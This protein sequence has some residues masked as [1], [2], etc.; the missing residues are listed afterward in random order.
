MSL[1]PIK[2]TEKLRAT[3]VRYLKTIYPF[4]DSYLREEFWHRLAEEDRLVKGPLL[5][6]SPPFKTGLTIEEMVA[7]GILHRDFKKLCLSTANLDSPPLP[8]QRPLY[9]HQEKAISN[10]TRNR[11]NLVVATGTGSGKTETFL[12]PILNHLLTEQEAGTLERP[13]VRA[14]L[15]YPMNALANDQ[16]M[17]LRILLQNFPA[18]TFGR[19]TGETRE[20]KKDA[21]DAFLSLPNAGPLIKNE[22]LSREEMRQKPPHILL[23]NYAML[24]YLL[25]RPQ[26]TELFDGLTG[27]HWRF[28]IVDEAHVYDGANGIEVAMLLRRLKDRVVNSQKGKLTCIATSATIGKGKEDF[29]KVAQFAQDLF[30]EPFEVEDVFEAERKPLDRSENVWGQGKHE[31]YHELARLEDNLMSKT[32]ASIAEKYGLP[33][34]LAA[35]IR[36]GNDA[37]AALYELLVGDSRLQTLQRRLLQEPMMLEKAANSIFPELT[38]AEANEAI[39]ALV[40]LAVRARSTA[41]SLPLLPARYHVFAR[42]TEGAFGCLHTEAHHDGKPRIYLNRHEQCAEPDCQSQVFELATCANCGVTYIVGEKI[43][44]TPHSFIHPLKGDFATGQGGQRVYYIVAEVLPDINEDETTTEDEAVVDEWQLQTLCLHCGAVAEHNQLHCG[45]DG[46]TRTI[47]QA[48]FNGNDESKMYCPACS[49]RSRSTVYRMLTGKD[50]PVSVLA[51]NLYSDL[52][53]SKNL[54]LQ[55]IPGQGRKLLM[56]ADSRQ[57]AAFFAPYFESNYENILQRRLINMALQQ[58]E[59]ALSGELRLNSVAKRLLQEAERAGIFTRRQDYDE[60]MSQMK[61]WLIRE[62][63]SWGFRQSLERLGL[64]QFKLVSPESWRPAAPLMEKPWC[65][66]A[67]EVWHLLTVLLDSVRRQGAVTFPNGVDPREEFFAPLNRPYYISDRSLTDPKYRRAHAVLGWKP[68]SG[69]NSRLDFLEKLLARCSPVIPKV[70][71]RKLASEALAKLWE[72]ELFA[73]VSGWKEYFIAQGLGPAGTAYQLDFAFWEW[74]PT[75]ENTQVWRCSHCRNLAYQSLRG[76]CAT[77]GCSGT[78]EP[79]SYEQL[80]ETDNHYRHLYGHLQ[81]AAISVQEHTAQWRAGK[82][83]EIQDD[84]VKGYVNVL[85]CSTTFELGVDVGALQ[86]VLMRNVP[87]TTANYLQ[88]AGRAGRREDSPAFVLT[89]AQRRSHDLAY[90]R[91]PEKIV[92]GIV[93]TPSVA[94]HNPKIVQRH[95][96]SVFIAA[97]L[98]WCV[99]KFGRFQERKELRIGN[100]FLP[101]V[102]GQSGPD[103]FREYIQ[104]FPNEAKEALMRIVPQEMQAE[105]QV[106]SWEWLKQLSNQEGS[107]VFDLAAAEVNAD[108]ELYEELRKQAREEDSKR[109]DAAAYLYRN[110]INTIK[111]RDLLNYF[112]RRNVLPK[113]GFPV[114]VVPLR[115]DHIPDDTARDVEL[116]RDL[117]IAISEFAPGSQLVAGKKLFTGGGLYKQPNKDWET[118]QF[119]ICQS[120]GRFNKQKG[121]TPLLL[122]LACGEGL[123]LNKPGFGGTMVKP[124]FGFVARRDA[125]LP[126]PGDQRPPRIYSSRAYFDNYYVPKHMQASEM[127]NDHTFEL[128]TADS[129]SND[130]VE[131]RYRYSRYGQLVQVNHGLGGRGFLVCTFCGHAEPAPALP[132]G[133]RRRSSRPSAAKHINPR[134]GKEC[135]GFTKILRLGHDFITDVLELQ[136]DGKLVHSVDVPEGKDLWWSLLYAL[137]EGASSALGISRTDLN[138]TLYVVRNSLEPAMIMYDDVPGGAGHV[139]RIKDCLPDVFIAARERLAV[140]ECGPETACHECLWNYYNQP[141]HDVLARGPALK[142]LTNVLQAAG[143]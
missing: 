134:T 36:R 72:S 83:R 67:N 143:L 106:E 142:F 24:E 121:D 26:D 8:Y 42:S 92:N 141:L 84:F 120:C 114:D 81:P 29:G 43:P 49:T 80:L 10:V 140:C 132:V 44:G 73:Q 75:T 4:Q 86:A 76:V 128:E 96:H 101:D 37:N 126:K 108:I 87:P 125:K 98:R 117:R 11:R 103:L 30:A 115:T 12:I 64:L 110:V 95:M 15:L 113:Y 93:H 85:S 65:L 119:A 79:V 138:G 53:P 19:Y 82:A 105:L 133:S 78:L 66:E 48:P 28:L 41:D 111:G 102:G 47:R 136:T 57:D 116:E 25:L 118:I 70:Q 31:M 40:N 16:L 60:K 34:F 59:A 20:S 112:G 90:Y 135:S 13:G 99:D 6:A 35:Q 100:F 55:E 50:A 94:V 62:M 45:C 91:Q 77:F 71:I 33:S 7:K 32:V 61:K 68:R 137:L 17:R 9:L 74:Q 52:P 54:E 127:A 88:R 109:G 69:S 27:R 124:E 23:T 63:T 122:C 39:V 21:E 51:S 14:L 46:P 18:I 97:F 123:P 89:F 130:L 38:Q 3:Y 56:F 58:N 22:L 131:F 104:S 107:G 5:E 2:T 139:R 1:H 129:L